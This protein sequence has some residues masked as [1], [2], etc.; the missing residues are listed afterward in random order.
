[1]SPDDERELEELSEEE[2]LAFLRND[3]VMG[4]AYIAENEALQFL[5]S[6]IGID[7]QIAITLEKMK[8]DKDKLMAFENIQEQIEVLD[9]EGARLEK[10]L[11]AFRTSNNPYE[12]DPDVIEAVK[13]TRS[14]LTNDYRKVVDAEIEKLTK[15][16][17]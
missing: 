6:P 14:F 1:M 3:P 15:K 11:K 16:E 10:S 12:V 13:Q 2:Q 9:R 5:E 7:A 4:P 8:D 17:G